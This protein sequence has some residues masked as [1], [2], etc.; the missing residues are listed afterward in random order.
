M[1]AR[2]EARTGHGCLHVTAL[3]QLL[4]VVRK[5]FCGYLYLSW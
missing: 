1:A 2:L 5:L 3:A 4:P